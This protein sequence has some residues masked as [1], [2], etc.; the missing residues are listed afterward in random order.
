MIQLTES[1]LRLAKKLGFELCLDM[2]A[3]LRFFKKGCEIWK[4]S[5]RW[6]T[7]DIV[8]NR[9]INY[10]EFSSLSKA[11]ERWE[12]KHDANYTVVWEIDIS[13]ETALGA[14][15]E[16][17]KYLTDPEA[18]ATMFKVYNERGKYLIFSMTLNENVQTTTPEHS[19]REPM[20]IKKGD[21][22]IIKPEW[23]GD[24]DNK[25]AWVAIEDQDGGQVRIGHPVSATPASEYV[26]PVA[27]LD[28]V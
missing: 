8:D 24:V 7:A 12:E 19:E 3:G 16:A 1:E 11:L 14:A 18:H 4:V 17:R 13:A 26:I 15:M 9:R 21:E 23:L 20:T 2:S 5:D 28:K 25:I 27:M 10:E 22:V 6:T